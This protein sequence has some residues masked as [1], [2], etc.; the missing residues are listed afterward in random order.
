MFSHVFGDSWTSTCGRVSGVSE[1]GCGRVNMSLKNGD[2]SDRMSLWT[3]KSMVPAA[4]IIR[5][6]SSAQKS[7]DSG[8]SAVGSVV[9][10]LNFLGV[11]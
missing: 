1:G 10:V 11:I 3:R 7:V 9:T 8:T 4:R 6:A 5:S 2:A